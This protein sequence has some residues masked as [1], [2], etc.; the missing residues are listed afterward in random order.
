M[1]H[2]SLL[3]ALATT[4][5]L[6]GA[7]SAMAGAEVGNWYVAPQAVY[8]DP[9]KAYL[10]DESIGGS[11]A[12]GKVLSEAWD[13][14]LAYVDTRHDVSGGGSKL[15]LAGP[16]LNFNRVFMRDNVV[17]PFIGFGINSISTRKNGTGKTDHDV[18]AA[19]KAGVLADI[20]SNGALQLSA[21]IGKRS[22]DF[23]QHLEDV[24]GGLGLRFNFGAPA[25]A[26]PVKA[27]APAP[28]PVAAP[29]PAP[30]PVAAPVAPPAPPAAPP[31]PPADDDKD[32]VPNAADRCPKTPA[33]DKVDSSG[34]GLNLALEVQF[35]TNS[36]VIKQESYGELDAFVQFLKDVPSVK[37]ELQGHTDSVGK[38]AYNLNLSQK[39]ADSVKA[40]IVGKGVDVA[41]VDAKGYGETKPVADNATVDGRAANRRVVFVR[42]DALN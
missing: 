9:D 39:R 4:A 41:R 25:K 38:D 37:G 22:D 31:A 12:I 26:A 34:C 23:T 10:A 40:Y 17:S 30:A 21:E 15:K 19:I 13:A 42:S 33:G 14:E 7:T 2:R 8:V 28:A 11:L 5:S 24:F 29:A 1:K 16:S 35:E 32:G 18:G 20:T 6:T 3:L 36:A 27:A